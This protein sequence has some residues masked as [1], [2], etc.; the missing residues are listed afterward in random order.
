MDCARSR[1]SCL[2]LCDPV[3]CSPPSA[4]DRRTL[5]AGVLA[6]VAMPSS[7]GSSWPRDWTWISSLTSPALP[8]RFFTPSTTWEALCMDC[9]G[10]PCSSDGKESACQCRRFR[11]NPWVRK[12]PWRREWQPTPVF[13]PGESHRERSL[14][15]YSPWGRK[16]V[17][18]S[19]ATKQ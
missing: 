17:R 6:W 18:H 5:Q 3:D 4:P 8:G 19:S 11:F 14:A 2:T 15:G 1:Q 16:T 9:C 13:L 12:I 7:K 10:L